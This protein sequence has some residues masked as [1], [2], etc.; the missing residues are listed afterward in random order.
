MSTI[1]LGYCDL[2]EGE[3][4]E[5][6]FERKGCWTCDYFGY[7]ADSPYVDVQEAAQLLKKS[8]STIKR[9]LK[10]GRLEGKLFVRERRVF[11]GGS[12]RKWLVKRELIKLITP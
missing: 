1:S 3:V 9:W 7:S 5:G 2:H 10:K 6:E 12:P 4:R 11:C 8:P